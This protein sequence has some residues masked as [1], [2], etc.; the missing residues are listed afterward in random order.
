MEQLHLCDRA[1]LCKY[2]IGIFPQF[3]ERSSHSNKIEFIP[4]VKR[5]YNITEIISISLSIDQSRIDAW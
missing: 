3:L 1:I 5:W 4:E 2:L